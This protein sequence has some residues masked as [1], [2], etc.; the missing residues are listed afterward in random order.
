MTT[1]SLKGASMVTIVQDIIPDDN[2]EDVQFV[3]LLDTIQKLG[4]HPNFRKKSL[5]ERKKPVSELWR[6]SSGVFSEQ[7]L[8]FEF[9]SRNTKLHSRNGIPRLEQYENQN[10]PSNSRSDSRN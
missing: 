1:G 6:Q 3:D 2:Q 8:E 4:K 9:H 10:S 5:S 7:L